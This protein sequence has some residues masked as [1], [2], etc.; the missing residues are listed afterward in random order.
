[1]TSRAL[2]HPVKVCLGQEL[3]WYGTSGVMSHTASLRIK[4]NLSQRPPFKTSIYC[5]V[6]IY[7]SRCLVAGCICSRRYFDKWAWLCSK[8][9]ART[10]RVI[11]HAKLICDCIAISHN[12][13]LI[14]VL[15]PQPQTTNL[16][17]SLK[18]EKV[19]DKNRSSFSWQMNF[20]FYVLSLEIASKLPRTNG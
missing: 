10:K 7:L 2:D 15:H 16:N 11:Y 5:L 9:D 4:M 13:H 3:Q 1:M 6:H 20:S 12:I 19:C 8:A 17:N 18:S 14:C